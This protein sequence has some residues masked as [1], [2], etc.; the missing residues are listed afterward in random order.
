MI[1]KE[2]LSGKEE[3]KDVPSWAKGNRPYVRENGKY[4]A[5]RLC[6]AQYGTGNYKTG[7]GSEYNKIKKWGDRA[8]E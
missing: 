6:D 5:K 7:P 2:G 8:F 4:F 3:A 1:A